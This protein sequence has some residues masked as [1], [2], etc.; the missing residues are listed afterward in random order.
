MKIVKTLLLALVL[1]LLPLTAASGVSCVYEIFTGSYCDS[2]DDGIG[3][4]N[5]IAAK[6]DYIQELGAD[7]IWLTPVTPSPSYHKYDVMDYEDIDPAF[8]TLADY[9]ALASECEARGITLLFDLVVNHTSSEHPWF[10]SAVQSLQSGNLSNP[11]IEYYQFTQGAGDHPVEGTDWYYAGD[12]SADMPELNLDN[13]AV[14]Q[15]IADITAFW[16]SHGAGGFRLDAVT[17]YY[18]GQAG[19]NR[20]FLAWLCEM[21]KAI[22]PDAFIVG[23]AWTDE[24]SILDLYQ[25]GIDALFN[26]PL[27][28]TGALGKAMQNQSGQ[29]FANRI[30]GWQQSIAAI[31]PAAVAAPFLSNHDQGRIS[32][33]LRLELQQEK[34]AA[35]LYLLSPGVPF[36][37]YGEELGMTGSGDDENKR[38][39]MLWSTTDETGICN[40]PENATQTQRLAT[41]ADEQETDSAS[42]LSFYRQ[43]LAF[44]ARYPVFVNGTAAVAETDDMRLAAFTLTDG[45]QTLLI[46]HNFSYDEA[47]FMPCEGTLLTVFDTGDTKSTAGETG[48]QIA[49][50]STAVW[51][52]E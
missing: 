36:V 38:L 3:D 4:L 17:H 5:G 31:N 46:A 27:S 1:C 9:D 23:E 22:D 25:S 35:V 41:G 52:L 51:E 13:A 12:F 37:Y 47:L 42:L 33:V 6:L 39:P 48:V 16:L 43:V 34:Q 21:V 45:T 15:E 14:R 29:A 30:V 28:S 26:F 49:P 18:T 32:G 40:P 50:R 7:G 11:Y 2:N 44:R 20:E 19:S 24:V 10:V 8:G